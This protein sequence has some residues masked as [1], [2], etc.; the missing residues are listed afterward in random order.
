MEFIRR[1]GKRDILKLQAA[2]Q[3]DGTGRVPVPLQPPDKPLGGG[4]ADLLLRLV[5]HRQ[6]GR[7][8]RADVHAVVAEHRHVVGDVHPT[9]PGGGDYPD[10]DVAVGGEDGGGIQ[11]GRSGKRDCGY[12]QGGADA[13]FGQ[14]D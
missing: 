1:S 9:L 10:G 7:H 5:D 6:G 14:A 11:P 2:L 4:A 3:P 13:A 8:H 12:C